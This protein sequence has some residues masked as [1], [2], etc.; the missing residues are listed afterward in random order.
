VRH[1]RRRAAPTPSGAPGE[2]CYGVTM[3]LA[4]SRVGKPKFGPASYS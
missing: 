4:F 1:M 3:I 2:A